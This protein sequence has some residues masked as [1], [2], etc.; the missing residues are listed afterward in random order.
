VVEVTHENWRGWSGLVTSCLY[1]VEAG[2]QVSTISERV[3]AT[4]RTLLELYLS[5]CPDSDVVRAVA[6]GEGVDGT[7]FPTRQD[8]DRCIQCGLCTRVCIDLGPAAIA[9]LGRGTEKT[10]GPRPDHVGEDCTGCLA[11][12]EICPTGEIDFTRRD[13]SLEIWKREFEVPVCTVETQHCRGCGACEQACPFAIPRVVARRD[14]EL[15]AGISPSTCTGCGIC[16]GAC[17]TGAITQPDYPDT[18]MTGQRLVAGDLRGMTVTYACSRSP[19]PA[20]VEGVIAV[21]C[22]GRIG[23]DEIL[24]CLARGADGVQL[25]CRDRDTC[26]YSLGGRLGEERV[27]TARELAAYAG[28]GG[29]RVRYRQPAAGPAGPADAV[30][31]FR[32]GLA[33][34]PLAASCPLSGDEAT[35]LDRTLAVLRWCKSRPELRQRIP[36]P[37][38]DRFDT[39]ESAPN[40]LYLGELVELDLLLRQLHP[41]WQLQQVLADAAAV[42]RRAGMTVRLAASAATVS[43]LRAER[44]IVLDESAVPDFAGEIVTFGVLAKGN[45]TTGSDDGTGEGILAA[46]D[47]TAFRFRI[48]PAERVAML[49][50]LAAAAPDRPCASLQELAQIRLLTRPGSWQTFARGEPITAFAQPAATGSRATRDDSTTGTTRETDT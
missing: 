47:R 36:A 49:A 39:N 18:D 27:E 33:R 46:A 28:L 12:A 20:S 10:V 24:A 30:A 16:A 1:P 9:P 38:A 19:L 21:P 35:G 50:R 3:R 13:G 43:A 41:E 34:S 48:T 15:V 25:L 23:V 44:L 14:G 17:P 4:R 45:D 8:A 5:R 31:A 42:L 6:R 32:D 22:I 11:C 26:P 7:A 2:L 37:I 40:I 29:E